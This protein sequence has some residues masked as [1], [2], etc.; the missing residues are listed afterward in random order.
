MKTSLMRKGS[1]VVLAMSMFFTL[2]AQNNTAQNNDIKNTQMFK[3]YQMKYVFGMKYNDS[4]VAKDAMYSM[5]A[6]DPNNDSLKM[7]LCYYYFE[8]NQYVSSLFVSADLLARNPDNINAL[9]INAMSYENMGARDKAADAYEALYL[10]TNEVDVLYQLAII[11]FELERYTECKTNLD[12]VLQDPQAKALKL[13]FAMDNNKQQEITIEAA[14]Y[15]ALGM[16]EKQQGNKE[17]A[18]K[19]FQKAL[20]LQPEFFLAD[21]NLKELNK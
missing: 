21:Q 8:N 9:K 12:I 19:N 11:Q 20:E 16:L 10:K 13:N 1:M 2:H 15:N 6:M 5:I 3:H 14:T 17:E 18:K 4:E 7:T